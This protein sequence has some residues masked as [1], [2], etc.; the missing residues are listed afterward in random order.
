MISLV[1]PDRVEVRVSDFVFYRRGKQLYAG[2][3]LEPGMDRTIWVADDEKH[4]ERMFEVLKRE[5]KMHN[6]AT[7]TQIDL[8]FIATMTQ[9]AHE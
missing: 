7:H 3:M 8:Q 4:A 6:P 9:E 5:I 2:T 1:F